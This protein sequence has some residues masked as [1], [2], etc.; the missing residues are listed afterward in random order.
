[1]KSSKREIQSRVHKMPIL[2]FVDQ[3]L[4]SFAGLIIF[5]PLLSKLELKRRLR[6]CFE[7]L[8]IGSIFGHHF[9]MLLLIVHLILGFR[10]LRDVD[11]YKDDPLV[12]R[13]LGLNKLPD[14][15]TISRALGDA[16]EM[17][18]SKARELLRNLVLERLKE[19]GLARI[20]LDFDGSVLSTSRKAEGSAVG[21]NKKKKGARSYY[22]LFCTVAQSGQVFD[23]YHRPGNVHDSNG[24][25]EFILSCISI[26]RRELPGVTVEARL[27]SAFFSDEIVTALD[28]EKVK[29]TISVPFERFP[30]LK[31]MIEAH[32]R[33]K[34]LDDTWS[35]FETGWK[36]KAWERRYRFLFIRQ[37]SKIINKEPIQLD[38][39]V[40]HEYGY[41]FKV[42]ITNKG[43]SAKKVLLYHN[44]RGSQESVFG[45]LKS[46][47][48]L[49]YVPV[50]YLYG[51]QLYMIAAIMAHNLNRELQMAT[52]PAERGTTAKRAP[53]WRFLELATLRHRLIQRAGRLTQPSGR[54]TLTLGANEAVK[55]ELLRFLEGLDKA[56]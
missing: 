25:M 18:V 19:L 23:F 9:I 1:M 55:N 20:T 44:G 24:A 50:R 34:A 12:K 32:K 29:F 54:L 53:L 39:F 51:N 41:E 15:A 4:T 37:K 40:P 14:V 47:S 3:T 49:E 45:E 48:Q 42:I 30:E 27:D 36:P 43:A 56:A 8:N 22:P 7:H 10:R 5:Q 31:K 26:I 2:R 13:I 21:F 35:C 17:S 33:W 46:Q 16:D 11:Y 52:A 38:L 6:S 28:E